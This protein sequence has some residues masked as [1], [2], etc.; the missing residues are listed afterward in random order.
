MFVRF[1]LLFTLVPLADLVLLLMISKSIPTW[2]TVM[3]V[4]GSGLLGAW[5]AKQQWNSVK[6]RIQNRLNMNEMPGELITDGMLVLLAGGLL[7]A[8][9][10]ITDALG[11]SLLVP[12]CRNWYKKRTV[13]FLKERFNVTTFVSP[14]PPGG[15]D[16]D[17]VEGEVADGPE[18]GAGEN[19]S[20]SSTVPLT[21]EGRAKTDLPTDSSAL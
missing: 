2:A 5:L 20:Q 19:D 18:T 13:E 4:V 11:I 7:I 10:L 1:F 6:S 3:I 8:P 14:F 15:A 21:I 12:L 17:I 16:D 9:G